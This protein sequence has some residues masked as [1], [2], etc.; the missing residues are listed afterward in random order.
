MNFGTAM[1][2][3]AAR[4]SAVSGL[5]LIGSRERSSRDRIW[6]A[7][8]ESD[9]DFQI[10]TSRPRLFADREWMRNLAGAEVR[11]Y[12]ARAARIGGVPKINVVLAGAEVDFVIIPAGVLQRAKAAVARGQ[13]R[14]EGRWRRV[15]QDLAIVIRPGWRFLKG[16]RAWGAL[17]R[18]VVAEVPD[19]RIGDG[20]ACRLAEGFV[21][22][23]VWIKRKIARGEFLAAQRMLHR[24]LAEMNFRLNHELRLRRSQRSFPEAR[25]I[26]RVASLAELA[27]IS[28]DARPGSRDL[29]AAL[30]NCARTFRELMSAL[31][32]E[33]W[34]WPD[35]SD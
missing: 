4:E 15:L 23:Y 16:E 9:W 6:R 31:V 21:C 35:L 8:A 29:R 17:Y 12:A 32:G 19:P 10:I 7:D 26:E 33:A 28:I 5:V 24:E 27:K 18:R 14:G 34:R 2:A 13:H 11:A 25:R 22:D 30:E 20:A 3:W 1:A